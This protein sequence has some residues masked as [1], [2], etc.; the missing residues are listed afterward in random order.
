MLSKDIRNLTPQVEAIQ[1][2]LKESKRENSS[3]D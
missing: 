1:R 2:E 3:N